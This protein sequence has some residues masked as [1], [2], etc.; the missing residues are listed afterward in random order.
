LSGALAEIKALV[1][2]PS[3]DRSTA[4]RRP[5]SPEDRAR[6]DNVSTTEC[7]GQRWM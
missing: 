5:T 6:S 4:L 3:L 2:Y 1:D 7:Q